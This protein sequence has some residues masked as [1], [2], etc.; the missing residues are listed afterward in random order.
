MRML[1][2]ELVVSYVVKST[3]NIITGA[4]KCH[5]QSNRSVLTRVLGGSRVRVMKTLQPEQ[6]L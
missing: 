6:Y 2:P 4:A 3:R 5:C 1:L